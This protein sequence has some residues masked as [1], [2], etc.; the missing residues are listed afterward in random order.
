MN[1]VLGICCRGSTTSGYN[2]EKRQQYKN[3]GKMQKD[4]IAKP[5][6][7]LNNT[8]L[9]EG[10]VRGYPQM[11]ATT[12]GGRDQNMKMELHWP[13][14]RWLCMTP[15]R[16]SFCVITKH[17]CTDCNNVI[18]DQPWHIQARQTSLLTENGKEDH[19][20]RKQSWP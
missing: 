18:L 2:G 3:S 1:G 13:L 15:E 20:K 12:I 4:I 19:C 16:K 14:C 9:N 10:K 6:R 5:A 8:R 7:Y 17:H 11:F